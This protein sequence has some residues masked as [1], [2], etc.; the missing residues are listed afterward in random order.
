MADRRNW[1]IVRRILDL[2]RAG[3]SSHAIAAKLNQEGVPSK[4]GARWYHTTV[5]KVVRRRE[6]Y[7]ARL[8]TA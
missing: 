8:S 2:S 6:W 7:Q 1:L 3:K 4:H 5:G